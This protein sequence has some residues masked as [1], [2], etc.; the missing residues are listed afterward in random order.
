MRPDDRR[1]STHR[2]RSV[3]LPPG[4]SEVAWAQE[5]IRVQN[6]RI[7][8]FLGCTRLIEEVADSNYA[9][10]HCS[11]DRL[12]KVWRQVQEVCRLMITELAPT[13]EARSAIPELEAARKNALR[14]FHTL[15]TAVIAEVQR[16]PQK[17]QAEQLPVVRKLLGLSIGRIHAFLRDA[18][19]EIVASDPRS[20]YDA[21]YFLSKQFAQDIEES[22]WLYSSVY[23]LNDY[24]NGLES[25]CREAFQRQ[26]KRLRKEAMIPHPAVWEDTK[27][28]IDTLR[29]ELVTKLIEVLSLRTIRF[30]DMKTVESFSKDIAH[31]CSSL[32]LVYE[33]GLELIERIKQQSGDGIE[34]REQSIRDLTACHKAVSQRM[35]D[36]V[37][38]LEVELSELTAYVPT[39]LDGIENRRS[40]M[41]S[42]LPEARSSDSG[43]LAEASTS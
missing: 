13:L 19:G 1:H 38:A 43:G 10:L 25:L 5:R 7:R 21:D 18:F 34:A 11:S 40:L 15:A 42:K 28:I 39:W 24:L 17:I 9:I 33:L 29:D 30:D 36:L 22:E 16:Y 26:V 35:V 41:V 37:S 32:V 2:P 12:R 31:R 8:S 23:E 4:V 27:P 6:P 14:D 3:D 20:R